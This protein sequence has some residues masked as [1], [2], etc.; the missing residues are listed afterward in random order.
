MKDTAFFS[1]TLDAI[2]SLETTI[3]SHI[4]SDN[5]M[6]ISIDFLTFWPLHV[7]RFDLM[8][9]NPDAPEDESGI[10]KAADNSEC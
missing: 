9:L 2:V 7:C 8:G 3:G 5:T 4:T 10:K 1:S 6:I